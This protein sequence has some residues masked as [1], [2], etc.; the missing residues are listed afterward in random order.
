MPLSAGTRLGPYEILEPIGAGGMGEVYRA[1]DTAL[2]R[3]VAIKVL[4]EALAH[5]PER[6]ARFKHEAKVLASLNHPNIGHIYGVESQALVMELVDGQT[7]GSLLKPGPLPIETAFDYARQI[8]EAL[9][10]AHDKGIVHRDLKPSNVMVTPAG[11]VKV[12]DFGLAKTVGDSHGSSNLSDSPT[13]TQSPTQAGVILGT[14]A[15][16]S[17][18]QARGASV[19][20]RSDI[21]TF[22][23]VLYEML[24]GKHAFA[25]ESVTDILA[26]IL[27]GEPDWSAL[28]AATPARIRELLRR[29][30]QRD[31]KQR[32]QAIAEARIAIDAAVSAPVPEQDVRP[33]PARAP[34]WP[35]AVAALGL[36]LAITAAVGWWRASRSEP[37]RPLM[38][39]S[40]EF[41]PDVKPGKSQGGGVLAL[42]PDG[43]LLAVVVRGADGATR[44]AT[45]RLDQDQ[46]TTLAGTEDATSPFFSPDGQWIAFYSD[47]KIKKISAGGGVAVTLC[48]AGGMITGSWGDDGNII[49]PLGWGSGLSRVP[50]AGGPPAPVTQLNREKGEYRHGWPQ[51]L[52]GSRA[53][54]FTTEHA[55]H[56]FDDA[57]IEVASLKTRERTVLYHGGFFARYLPSS[58]RASGHLAWVHHNVLYAAPFDLDRLALTGDPQPVVEDINNAE[59]EGGDFSFSQAGSSVYLSRE[60]GLQRS[61]FWLDSAGG[62]RPLLP[63]SGRYGYPRFSPEGKRMAFSLSDDQ[64]HEDLWVRD[65]ERDTVSRVTRLPGQNVWPVWTPDGRNLIFWSSNPASPGLYWIPADGSGVAQRLTDGKIQWIQLSISPDGKRL[66]MDRVNNSG[67]VEL[68]TAPVEGDAGH[69][70]LGTPEP[71]LQTPFV[72]I[73]PAFSPDGRWLAYTS[74]EPGKEGLWVVPFPGPGGGWLISSRGSDPVWS[75]GG[76]GAGRELFF[77]EGLRTIMVTAY[78]A[79]GDAFEFSKPRVWSPHPMLDLGSPPISPYDLAPDGKRFAVVLNA[80]GTAD[81]KPIKH[82]T[83][84]VNFFDELRRRIPAGGK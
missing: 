8:A 69:P 27:R 77:L 40:V 62:T 34:V 81:P 73:L 23:V 59:D 61:I 36:A 65:L 78:T 31:R 79:R 7:L 74:G 53:V 46:T 70:R 38:R 19:D 75:R 22:G 47:H 26:G 71:F 37:L 5:D 49:A 76:L 30:L 32:L 14:A 15:Y 50:S 16:M 56:T 1:R 54:L 41:G 4:A 17:P 6:L 9:E 55:G 42:S 18:E 48:E 45:R 68:W 43:T 13:M 52:P 20:K 66:A 3:D 60:G 33:L 51:V 2:G 28:P 82:L 39:L 67:G 29:C 57:D 11:V 63:A 83:F 12:L 44:L 64:N 25:G 80:D 10:A 35:W 21:W 24:A 58:G 72:T 84:L